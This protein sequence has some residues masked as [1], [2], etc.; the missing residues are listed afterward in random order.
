MQIL[1]R[2]YRKF[3]RRRALIHGF[4]VS[5][6]GLRLPCLVR[7]ISIG[8]A[9]LEVE[10]PHM[11]PQRITLLVEVDDFEADCDI[12]H[13]TSHAVGVNF[14]DI[15]IGRRGID[16]RFAGPKLEPAMQPVSIADLGRVE[17][18]VK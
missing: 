12:R 2:E 11:L 9:L 13:K 10:D 14:T 7:N 6:R 3:G 8:G 5:Q 16:T 18:I 1:S 17:R 15:R 4:V